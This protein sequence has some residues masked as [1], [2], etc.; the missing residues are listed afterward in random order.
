MANDKVT[1]SSFVVS[2]IA[3]V[4][5]FALMLGTTFAWFTDSVTNTGNKI[6]GGEL[7]VDLELLKDGVYSSVRNMTDPI[8]SYDLWE[9]GYTQ[10]KTLKIQNEGDLALKYQLHL[11]AEK[12]GCILANVIDVYMCFGESTATSAADLSSGSWW[13]CG[14]LAEMIKDPE[15]FT[16]GKLLPVGASYDGALL[17]QNGVA[18]GEITATVALHMRETADNRYQNLTLGNID[19]RLDATQFNFEEDSFGSD[20]DSIPADVVDDGSYGGVVWTLTSDG[21]LT[22]SPSTEAYYDESAKR[23]YAAGAWRDAV[24]YDN[25]SAKAIVSPFGDSEIASQ[26]TSLV[27]AEGV[28]SIGSF[29][30][31]FP[32]LTG[33][34]VIP[35]TVTYIGQEA[36]QGTQIKKLI[37]AS[38][39]TEELCV[40]PG[41]FKGLKVEEVIFPTDRPAVH[42]HSWAF[43]DCTKLKSVTIP[44]NVVFQGQTHIEYCGMDS[45]YSSDSQVFARCTSLETIIFGSQQAYDNFFNAAGNR[46]NINAIGGVNIIVE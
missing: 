6:R 37:F 18:I 44:G 1:K 5:C 20:Y 13:K 25:G 23:T 10:V 41:A 39:G 45:Y 8:F 11:T 33:E 34:V 27:I 31:K 19:V 43:N 42:I 38:G 22:V 29:S 24:R 12:A 46:G 4:V 7:K 32:N 26:V 30:A 2:L 14:T 21:T 40:A 3:I 17:G 35:S 28:T 9:P 36:F 15:G 16:Q